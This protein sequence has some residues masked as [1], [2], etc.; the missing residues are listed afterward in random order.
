MASPTTR[1]ERR[2]RAPAHP[3]TPVARPTPRDLVAAPELAVLAALQHILE[4]STFALLATHP[5]LEGEPSHLRPPDSRAVLADQVIRL[6]TRLEQA[7]ARY[8]AAVLADLRRP[9][10]R[11]DDLPF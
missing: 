9:D 8:H 10:A 1:R 6:A 4:L 5:E 3:T 11:D 2:R 7:T